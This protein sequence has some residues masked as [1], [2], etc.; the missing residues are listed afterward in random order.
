M[1]QI[2]GDRVCVTM[3][4]KDLRIGEVT[5]I[6]PDGVNPA[7]KLPN[8][9]VRYMV[10]LNGNQKSRWYEADRVCDAAL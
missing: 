1:T 2:I 9:P 3:K 5:R 8:R 6:E 4:D 10:R 7:T